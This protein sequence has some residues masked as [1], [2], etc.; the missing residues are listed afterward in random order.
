MTATRQ[1]NGKRHKEDVRLLG[2]GGQIAAAR[3]G[4]D[5]GVIGGERLGK[6]VLL[7]LLEKIEI[8]LFLYLLLALDGEQ[9]LGLV[10]VGRQLAGGHCLAA[11]NTTHLGAKADNIVI[12]RL[13]DALLHLLK[14]MG[15]ILNKGA[16]F[17]T[18]STARGS[19]M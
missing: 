14:R 4:D 18:C 7:A 3:S 6:L 16:F 8:E 1:N 17:T 10:G 11:V 12:Y 15:E 5:A 19:D 9:I 13:D 2:S